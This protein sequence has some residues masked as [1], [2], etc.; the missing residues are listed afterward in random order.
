MRRRDFIKVIAGSAA[1][2]PFTARAQ[3]SERI[4]R[5]GVLMPFA[6]NNPEG[7]ARITAFLAQG[8]AR[9]RNGRQYRRLTDRAVEPRHPLSRAQYLRNARPYR[10]TRIRFARR[11]A[12]S[13]IHRPFRW[14]LR[15]PGE[16][17][18]SQA[19]ISTIA[20]RNHPR[21]DRVER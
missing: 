9:D 8:H 1:T 2:W 19:D 4:R 12:P 10:R 17:A 16:P 14:R 20:C 11:M 3:Q 18:N 7:Q 21:A 13:R 5:I 15:V 6:I